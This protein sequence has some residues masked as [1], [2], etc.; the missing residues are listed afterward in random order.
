MISGYQISVVPKAIP[1]FGAPSGISSVG[2]IVE[3]EETSFVVRQLRA[4][5]N[6]IFQIQIISRDRRADTVHGPTSAIEFKIKPVVELEGRHKAVANND[7]V[8]SIDDRRVN[9]GEEYDGELYLQATTTKSVLTSTATVV[10][11]NAIQMIWNLVSIVLAR[12]VSNLF[13]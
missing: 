10:G 7:R 5:V 13:K 9:E 4:S 12:Q 2:A 6:Y 3:K 1:G 8:Y 11:F